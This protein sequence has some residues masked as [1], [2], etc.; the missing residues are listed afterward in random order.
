M[1]CPAVA[2]GPSVALQRL[3]QR[4]VRSHGEAVLKLKINAEALYMSPEGLVGFQGR[5]ANDFWC[6]H[7]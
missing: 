2:D 4:G 6:R 1:G 7:E 3:G 5:N